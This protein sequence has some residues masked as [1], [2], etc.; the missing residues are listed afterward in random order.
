MK[1]ILSTVMLMALCMTAW[2]Q[3]L[4]ISGTVQDGDNG[5]PLIGVS[6][7]EEG[8]TNG[9]VTDFDGNFTLTVATNSTIKLS[10]LG[11]EP[12]EL[13]AKA[14]LG[15]ITM[16]SVALDE[17][18]QPSNPT[19][20]YVFRIGG[21]EIETETWNGAL[22]EIWVESVARSPEWIEVMY[23]QLKP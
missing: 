3:T 10:Y 20:T 13:K 6:V 5:E 17:P 8:S 11:Y 21:D 23:E 7:L 14:N 15:I 22:D 4:K 12:K 16:Q 9:T 18:E 19:V 2:A 1:K